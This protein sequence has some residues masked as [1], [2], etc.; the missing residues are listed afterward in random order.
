MADVSSSAARNCLIDGDVARASTLL[1]PAVLAWCLQ[2]GPWRPAAALSTLPPSP[3]RAVL[4]AVLAACPSP[5]VRDNASLYAEKM[6]A[7]GF[8]NV[9][10]ILGYDDGMMQEMREELEARGV[11]TLDAVTIVS[12]LEPDTLSK[13]LHALDMALDMNTAAVSARSASPAGTSTTLGGAALGASIGGALGGAFGGALGGAFG[14]A[15]GGAIGSSLGPAG[16][17]SGSSSASQAPPYPHAPPSPLSLMSTLEALKEHPL[18]AR[19]QL[20]GFGFVVED[21]DKVGGWV[22]VHDCTAAVLRVLIDGGTQEFTSGGDSGR[23][24]YEAFRDPAT[25]ELQQRNCK[26]KVRL[27]LACPRTPRIGITPFPG[28]SS[29]ALRTTSR[30]RAM[31][32]PAMFT[33][34]LRTTSRAHAR[35]TALPLTITALPLTIT[36][37]PLTIWSFRASGVVD[38]ASADRAARL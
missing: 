16:T 30:A 25:N 3:S 21:E 32:T 34:A 26:F 11:P 8:D 2:H 15:I 27:P 20:S 22:R 13:T 31:F 5:E 36:A 17:S 38:S 7:S 33:P 6:C 37:L 9:K 19:L 14:A 23:Y 28:H 1:H 4:E 18:E 35:F 24:R 12:M 29:P 10:S